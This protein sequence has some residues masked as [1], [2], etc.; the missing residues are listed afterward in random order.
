MPNP[1]GSENVSSCVP[2]S[3]AASISGLASESGL[4]RSSYVRALLE[5]AVKK[6]RLFRLKFE[7]FEETTPIKKPLKSKGI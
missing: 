4:S 5:D 1:K 3:L 6:H 7:E 2:E